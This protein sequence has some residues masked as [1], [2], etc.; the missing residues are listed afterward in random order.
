MEIWMWAMLL[1]LPALAALSVLYYFIVVRG[2]RALYSVLPK[3]KLVVFL[4]RERGTLP[5]PRIDLPARECR[6]QYPV[7]N[8]H[9]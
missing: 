6:P 8:R 1:K 4:F 9:P 7:P 5:G 3:S 2:L